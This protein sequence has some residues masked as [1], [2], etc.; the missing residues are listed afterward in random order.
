MGEIGKWKLHDIVLDFW[1]SA[2][3]VG[4]GR[5]FLYVWYVCVC[6]CIWLDYCNLLLR[7]L[8]FKWFTFTLCFSGVYL[9]D[10]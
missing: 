6:V 3:F 2:I 7:L 5:M 1:I 8:I 4:I 10:W 9:S